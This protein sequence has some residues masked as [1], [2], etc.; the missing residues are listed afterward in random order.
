MNISK[1]TKVWTTKD[2]R[3]IRVCD[4]ADRHLLNTMRMLQR[5]AR[6]KEIQLIQE[7]AAALHIVGGELAAM[8]IEEEIDRLL[9]DG[10]SPYDIHPAYGAMCIECTRR[11]LI[12]PE[13]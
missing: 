1:Q 13:R 6:I 7:G 2:G 12:I 9:E 8:T 3:R 4:M 5:Q 10:V 11:G